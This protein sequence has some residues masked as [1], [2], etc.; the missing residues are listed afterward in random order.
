MNERLQIDKCLKVT[1]N[2]CG[3]VE[4]SP[5]MEALKALKET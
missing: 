2:H 5:L 4:H 3:K 1:V